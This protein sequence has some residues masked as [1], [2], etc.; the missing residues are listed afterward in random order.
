MTFGQ[1]ALRQRVSG[2]AYGLSMQIAAGR[3]VL[4][5]LC[6]PVCADPHVRR[7]LLH[8][9][10]NDQFVAGIDDGPRLLEETER[11]GLLVERDRVT[12]IHHDQESIGR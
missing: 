2:A 8:R 6:E 4:E 7:F 10:R 5:R 9:L 3:D 11:F 1:E 12:A